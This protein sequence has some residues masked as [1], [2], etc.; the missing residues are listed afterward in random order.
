MTAYR[1]KAYMGGLQVN[2]VVEAADCKE[3]ILRVSFPTEVF[4]TT[5]ECVNATVDGDAPHAPNTSSSSLF[6]RLCLTRLSTE[7]A[8][9]AT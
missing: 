2:Q 7:Q 9:P 8:W 3:A 5:M 6:P 4:D 1:I